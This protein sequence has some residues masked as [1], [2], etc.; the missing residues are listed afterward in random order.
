MADSNGPRT[1]PLY[2]YAPSL[3]SAVI[4]C[5]LFLLTTLLHTYQMIRRRIWFMIPLV[6]GGYC[7]L[8]CPGSNPGRLTISCSVSFVGYACRTASAQQPKGEYTLMPYVI[9]NSYILIAPALFAATIYMT[10]GRIIRLTDGDKHSIVSSRKLTWFFLL[11]DIFCFV[12]Q[13]SGK[14][15]QKRSHLVGMMQADR[16]SRWQFS[17]H[18]YEGSTLHKSQDG[19]RHHP[20]WCHFT[21]DLV[22]VL[23]R[24]R[25]IVSLSNARCPD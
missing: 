18:S 19:N 3:A 2:R 25:S 6:V 15:R 14:W 16:C 22:L 1:Y 7:E 17:G 12:L 24:W 4:F 9:Q 21:N 11:G 20:C 23:F 5:I 8:L 10:L 13:G